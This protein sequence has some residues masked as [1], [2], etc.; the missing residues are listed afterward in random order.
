MTDGEK[1]LSNGYM[2]Y[3][4]DLVIIPKEYVKHELEYFYVRYNTYSEAFEPSELDRIDY[5]EYILPDILPDILPEILPDR[6]ENL[7]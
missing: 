1:W 4:L 3:V 5:P 7:E 6:K 2:T